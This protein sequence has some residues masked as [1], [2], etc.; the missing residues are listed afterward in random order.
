MGEFQTVW[1]K[2]SIYAGVIAVGWLIQLTIPPHAL[3]GHA[4][5]AG[6][7]A[8]YFGT[9]VYHGLTHDIDV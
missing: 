4:I 7:I 3:L 1:R 2:M 9:P 5:A 8:G 6:G